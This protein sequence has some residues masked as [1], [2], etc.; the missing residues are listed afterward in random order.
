MKSLL[1]G[2]AVA[3]GLALTVG[4]SLTGSSRTERMEAA[5]VGG[6]GSVLAPKMCLFRI[7][8][9]SRPEDDP[10]LNEA[11]WRVAD[12]QVG[13]AEVRR[14]LQSNGLRVGVISGDLPMEVQAVLNAPLLASW[15]CR[16]SSCP[17]G[18]S[19]SSIRT[20]RRPRR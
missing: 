15:R 20:R 5:R 3:S 7:A 14:A 17:R 1:A 4:C 11:L 16:R 12:E 19:R 18:T 9:A 8:V 10:A 6:S 2:V 13:D